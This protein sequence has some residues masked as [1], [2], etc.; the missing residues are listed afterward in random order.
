MI[1]RTRILAGIFFALLLVFP[2]QAQSLVT[3]ETGVLEIVAPKGGK[4]H[5][6]TVELA[7]SDR[8]LAQ[9][10]MF[11]TTLAPDAGMLFDFGV[12]RPI[13]MWMKNTLLPL[14]ILFI[15]TKG[16]VTGIAP[17]AVPMSTAVIASPGPVRAVL[18]L[19]AGTA[20]RLGLK[21][22]HRVVHPL[23]N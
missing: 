23:F 7:I 22:G 14:D 4:R 5:T 8:Q 20:A 15:D 9:G 21:A 13:T 1:F 16:V 6:I 10:L 3:F 2:A 19:N 18:E 12:P 17:D 11:R